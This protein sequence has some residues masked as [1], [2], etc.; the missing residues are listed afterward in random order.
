MGSTE[1]V[2][3]GIKA[4]L[5]MGILSRLAVQED[6]RN[7]SLALVDIDGVRFNR[8]LYL[9]TRKNRQMSPLCSA[10][11]DHLRSCLAEAEGT[12]TRV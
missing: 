10:F 8:P 11:I 12:S 5:G 6:V 7:G 2:R 1:A 3:Q 9:V 4:R